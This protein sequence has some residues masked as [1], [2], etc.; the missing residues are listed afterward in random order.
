MSTINIVFSRFPALD[1]LLL[2]NIV[3]I[4]WIKSRV[5]VC[6][7]CETWINPM[8]TPHISHCH[9]CLRVTKTL[10]DTLADEPVL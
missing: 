10:D 6:S 1:V 2:R 3:N 7:G 5:F 8:K 9:L 4:P